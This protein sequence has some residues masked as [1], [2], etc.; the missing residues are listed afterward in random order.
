MSCFSRRAKNMLIVLDI[1]RGTWIFLKRGFTTL[2]NFLCFA[3]R[4]T[5]LDGLDIRSTDLRNIKYRMESNGIICVVLINEHTLVMIYKYSRCPI[6]ISGLPNSSEF[7]VDLPLEPNDLL[8][9]KTRVG[10]LRRMSYEFQ[11]A[12]QS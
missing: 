8:L 11:P 1:F 9:V 5:K 7:F 3:P 10:M 2:L 4:A 12:V 6:V